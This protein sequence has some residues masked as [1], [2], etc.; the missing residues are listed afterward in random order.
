MSSSLKA[1]I[2]AISRSDLLMN[3]V[4]NTRKLKERQRR[5]MHDF[6]GCEGLTIREEI[7]KYGLTSRR[8]ILSLI[9]GNAID[10]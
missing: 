7:S 9:Q 6:A 3:L 5:P 4:M 10:S 2:Q 1:L 8:G